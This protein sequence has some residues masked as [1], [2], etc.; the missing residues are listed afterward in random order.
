MKSK[1]P[2]PS[3]AERGTDSSI[4]NIIDIRCN[5]SS[6]FQA[7]TNPPSTQ[8]LCQLHECADVIFYFIYMSVE[9]SGRVRTRVV[10]L[11]PTVRLPGRL[12][13]CLCVSLSICLVA[14]LSSYLSVSLCMSVY[15]F[16][17]LSISL[18]ADLPE[19]LHISFSLC[20]SGCLIVSA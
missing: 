20:L 11:L 19:S 3:T 14:F 18:Y 13:V 10:S 12:S 8:D 7:T 16:P 5:R 4:V 6:C 2:S 17:Y 15:P 1:S 9:V